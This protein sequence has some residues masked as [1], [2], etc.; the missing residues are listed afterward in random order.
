MYPLSSWGCHALLALIGLRLFWLLAFRIFGLYL[1]YISINNGISFNEVYWYTKHRKIS[2]SSVRFRLWG[3][4]KKIIIADLKV[5]LYSQPKGKPRQPKRFISSEPCTIYPENKLAVYLYRFVLRLL[6]SANIDIKRGQLETKNENISFAQLQFV[7]IKHRS[8]H[9]PNVYRFDAMSSIY[10]ASGK[11]HSSGSSIPMSSGCCGLKASCSISATTGKVSHFTAHIQVDDSEID[12]LHAIKG[13]IFRANKATDANESS[14][15]S[16]KDRQVI[17]SESKTHTTLEGH[18]ETFSSIHKK[19]FGAFQECSISIRNTHFK[20]FPLFPAND[21][22]DLTDYLSKDDVDISVSVSVSTIA[23]NI[24]RITSKSAGYDVLFDATTDKP[25]EVNTSVSILKAF[26]VSKH[27][28]N[29]GE[30]AYYKKDE[31]LDIPNYSLALKTNITDR[32]ANGYGFEKAVSEL[33]FSCGSPVID[34]TAD[35]FALLTYNYVVAKKLFTLGHLKKQNAASRFD[36]FKNTESDSELDGDTQVAASE[37]STPQV[38]KSKFTD[39]PQL[40]E[41]KVDLSPSSFESFETSK[42]RDEFT[43]RKSEI[44]FNSPFNKIMALINEFYPRLDVKFTMEQPRVMIRSLNADKSTTKMLMISYSMIVLHIA[45]TLD[46]TYVATCNLLHPCITFSERFGCHQHVEDFCG[47]SDLTINCNISR[48]FKVTT[49][50]NIQ[51]VYMNLTKPDVLNGISHIIEETTRIV[52]QNLTSGLIN[53][54]FDAEIVQELDLGTKGQRRTQ[55]PHKDDS[56]DIIF[57]DCPMWFVSATLKVTDVD[58][59]LGS[60]SP[61]LPPELISKLSQESQ[62]NEKFV[63]TNSI[64]NLSIDEIIFALRSVP[65][66]SGSDSMLAVSSSETLSNDVNDHI[67]WQIESTIRNNKICL[68]ENQK[69]QQPIMYLPQLSVLIQS[70]IKGQQ[71][72]VDSSVEVDEVLGHIDR[73]SIFV[74]IGS[75]YLVHQ[76]IVTPINQLCNKL[77]RNMESLHRNDS[78]TKRLFISEFLSFKVSLPKF[79]YVF[80]LSDEFKLYLQLFQLN[81]GGQDSG[82]TLSSNFFRLLVNSTE[83]K[84]HWNR[85]LCADYLQFKVNDLMGIPSFLFDANSIR[86]IQPHQFAVYRLFDNL[87]VFTKVIK[88]LL[89]SM[90]LEEKSQ[91]V[92]PKESPPLNIP[93]INI[94]AK[95]IFFSIED[96]PFEAELGMIYQ[97][98]LQEQKKRLEM[99][100]VLYGKARTQYTSEESLSQKITEIQKIMEGSWIRKVKAYKSRIAQEIIDNQDFL[101]GAEVHIKEDK[102]HNILPYSRTAPLCHM[103]LS[104]VDLDLSSINFPFDDI[105]RFVHDKGQGVPGDT[106]YNLVIPAYVDLCVRELRIHARDYP[107]PLLNLPDSMDSRGKG[108]SLK[109]KGNLII[110]EALSL[111]EEHIRRLEVQLTKA[112]SGSQPNSFD[113]LIIRKSMSTVKFYTDLDIMF[114]SKSPSR[115]VWGQSYSFVIQQIMASLDQFSKPPVDPSPKLGFWD[116][117]RYIFHGNCA[118]KTSGDACIEFAFKGDRDPY[119]LFEKASGFVLSFRDRVKWNVNSNDDSL[120]FCKVNSNKVLWYIPNYLSA[121]LVCWSRESHKSTYLPELNQLVTSCFGYYLNPQKRNGKINEE[122]SV[123]NVC[124]K[125]V[126]ELSGGVDFTLGFLLQRHASESGTISS[127]GKLH[128]EINLNNPAYVKEGHD[129]YKGFRT[130]R[131]HMAITL[132]AHTQSSYNTI[133]LSPGVFQQFFAWWSLFKSNMMLQVRRGK[134]FPNSKKSTK[135]S[136]HLFTNKFLFHIRDLFL[137]H[138]YDDSGYDVDDKVKFI[139]MRAK[140]SE[141]LVDLHQRKEERI[142]AHKDLSRHKKIMKMNFNQAE[143]ALSKID[144][145]MMCTEYFKDIYEHNDDL[146]ETET[147]KSKCEYTIFDKDYQ[148]FDDKDYVEAFAPLSGRKREKMAA[149]PFMYSERFAFIRQTKSPDNI[150]WGAE[151]THDCMLGSTDVEATGLNMFEARIS[152]LQKLNESSD[153][154]YEDSHQVKREIEALQQMKSNLKK[155]K[156]SFLKS[157]TIEFE[158]HQN[159]NFN[160]KFVLISMLLKWNESVRNLF[161]RYIYFVEFRSNMQ[162]YLSYEFITML[163]GL[164]DRKNSND[165]NSSLLSSVT[166]GVPNVEKLRSFLNEFSTSQDRIV[167]FD[168]IIRKVSEDET[169]EESFKIEVI[170]PQIQLHSETVDNSVVLVTAPV[171]ESKILTINSKKED[172]LVTYSKE[173]ETRF[174]ILLHDASV[175]VVDKRAVKAQKAP[176]AIKSYGSKSAWPPF[177][178]IEICKNNSLAQ[179]NIVLV[180]RMSMMLTYDKVKASNS[181][182]DQIEV[183]SA[184]SAEDIFAEGMDRLRVD[185]PKLEINC[186]SS[187]YFSLYVTIL[188]L[189]LYSEPRSARMAEKLRQLKFT[190]DFQDFSALHDRLVSLHAYL[191]VVNTIINN[192]SFRHSTRMS[193]EELNDYILLRNEKTENSAEIYLMLKTLLTGDIFADTSAQPIED[194]RIAADRIIL[195]ILTD[196]RKPIL[197]LSIN[198]GR[199]KRVTKEDGSNHN[200]VEIKSLEG[201]SLVEGA[202]YDKFLEPSYPPDG[203]DLVAVEWSMK[204]PIGG[205]KII[206]NFNISSQPLNVKLDEK[207]GMQLM[208]FIFHMENS[209]DYSDSPV[210]KAIDIIPNNK[211]HAGEGSGDSDEDSDEERK[212]VRFRDGSSSM[213]KKKTLS[214]ISGSETNTEVGHDVNEMISRSKKYLSVVSF[215]CQSFELTISLKMKHGFKRWLNVN[216]FTLILPEWQIERTVTSMLGVVDVFKKLVIKTLLSSSGSLLANKM[217]SRSANDR[218]RLKKGR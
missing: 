32:F 212:K 120:Q 203:N 15:N 29:S 134:L 93:V 102:C 125:R 27:Y 112:S 160:N 181:N 18:L 91:I 101:F 109:L 146:A 50:L 111:E 154:S 74:I 98:G 23:F 172:S 47:L 38:V 5:Q 107:L 80:S 94:K 16:A 169:F 63:G 40:K 46:N 12:V 36:T 141:F 140:V 165:A 217:R 194:W 179:D 19:Y 43:L 13:S 178:G 167:N 79:N 182:I 114:G 48:D 129:S 68:L 71:K 17:E 35:Q 52:N 60:I 158:Q 206:N 136:E 197:N 128:W 130:D 84:G 208:N 44:V 183:A 166:D 216:Q 170:N 20:G 171:L 198:N 211:E 184:G 92:S 103:I 139:G 142:D 82:I 163:E 118:V 199:Y 135:F 153:T 122:K 66:V 21:T 86:I 67:F 168:K 143:V 156:R 39:S 4:S 121:P 11:L 210:S 176:W 104:G 115:F 192:Y 77:R 106:K 144:L 200:R 89:K 34:V 61:L 78:K 187:Q 119:N 51:G 186:T 147:Q 162:K 58:L 56:L 132:V 22:Q 213:T 54:R 85:L 9:E 49:S 124:A 201:R 131:V 209:S 116:K 196:E 30:K 3:N 69:R 2:A 64:L 108:N 88:H 137:S 110:N 81:I 57:S 70:A 28:D 189:I 76:T 65:E 149:F 218:K 215:V 73:H 148:W 96:D 45:T 24:A 161:L 133:H 75:V 127:D 113:K 191:D 33:I 207:T 193:N 126:V 95:Q 41:L 1:G 123:H 59:R 83:V 90:K 117:F 180:R 152:E 8:A 87:A 99:M 202:Y 190:I 25:L 100:D 159:E 173:L 175:L 205:I 155:E 145:R 174:G 42:P 150:D 164:I 138:I 53:K 97:L 14:T 62:F 195:N 204:R 26:F 157:S 214:F 37:P 185:V 7:F 72:V 31:I 151:H 105:P 55:T 6:P 10:Q 188:S 177:L